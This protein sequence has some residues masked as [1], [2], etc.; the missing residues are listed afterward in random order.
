MKILYLITKS[1]LGGAQTYIYE[2][3]KYFIGKGNVVR[4]INY[5]GDWL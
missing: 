2:L 1:K 3:S 4:I 5:S